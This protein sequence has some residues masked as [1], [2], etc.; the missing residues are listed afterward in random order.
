M[1]LGPLVAGFGYWAMIGP[2]LTL[3]V[4]VFP[5]RVRQA[6]WGI[7]NGIALIMGGFLPFIVSYITYIAG[8]NFFAG[9]AFPAIAGFFLPII[10]ILKMPE[11]HGKL[12]E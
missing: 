11:S 1:A 8:G 2:Q 6:S 7:A 4:E 10:G 9:L 5:T 3:P 12:A